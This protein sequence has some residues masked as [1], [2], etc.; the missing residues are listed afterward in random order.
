M[1][2]ACEALRSEASVALERIAY[3]NTRRVSFSTARRYFIP[4][5]SS[6]ECHIRIIQLVLHAVHTLSGC[7]IFTDRLKDFFTKACQGLGVH[8]QAVGGKSEEACGLQ[9]NGL[10]G[11]CYLLDV[12]LL[13]RVRPTCL[14]I[15]Q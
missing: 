12:N 2:R 9:M 4:L 10:I 14:P 11:A 6:V 15:I 3:G 1:E 13:C 8:G 7:T 5:R